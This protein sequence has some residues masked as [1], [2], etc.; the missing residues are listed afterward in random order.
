M[1][2][3]IVAC[4]TGLILAVTLAVSGGCGSREQAPPPA[5]ESVTTDPLEIEFPGPAEEQGSAATPDVQPAD[6]VKTPE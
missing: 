1:F 3:R 5:S 4:S 2:A 6:E